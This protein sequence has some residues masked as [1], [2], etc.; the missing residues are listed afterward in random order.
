M[1]RTDEI[2]TTLR[3]LDAADPHAAATGPRARTDRD[4]ILATAPA[5]P[6]GRQ[7]GRSAVP[8]GPRPA[9]ARRLVLAGGAVAAVAATMV[10][11]P[12]LIGG[13]RAFATWTAA[14]EGMSAQESADAAAS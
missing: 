13:D 12:S 6:L 8:A 14:P 3:S 4:A 1:N 7:P 10:V 5:A 9:A 11:L 2:L